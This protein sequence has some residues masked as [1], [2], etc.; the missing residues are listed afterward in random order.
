MTLSLPLRFLP[1][2]FPER[3]PELSLLAHVAHAWVDSEMRVVGHPKLQFWGAH[4][5]L[6]TVVREVFN[7]FS[8]TPPQPFAAPSQPSPAPPPSFSQPSF[9]PST[10]PTSN[11]QSSQSSQS[12]HSSSQRSWQH[13]LQHA[14]THP[15][16]QPTELSAW[17]EAKTNNPLKKVSLADFP[18]LV[19]LSVEELEDI[20]NSPDAMQVRGCGCTLNNSTKLHTPWPLRTLPPYASCCPVGAGGFAALLCEHGGGARRL[21]GSSGADG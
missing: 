13:Q 21:D 17:A 10:L 1:P 9:H 16:A 19:A 2:E 14:E 5:N 11:F 4:E 12:S 6:G 15:D 8:R 20:L 18:A 7:E 3:A